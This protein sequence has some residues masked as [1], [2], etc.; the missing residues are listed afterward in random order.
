[1][2]PKYTLT[3]HYFFAVHYTTVYL[4]ALHLVGGYRLLKCIEQHKTWPT[5]LNYSIRVVS[6]CSF[7]R[8]SV[9][10]FDAL[11]CNLFEPSAL[12]PSVL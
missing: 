10:C 5:S 7:L 4:N 8:Y 6:F 2:L 12:N 3:L 9:L 11:S 1:M